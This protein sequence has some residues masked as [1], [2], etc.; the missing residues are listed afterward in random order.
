VTAAVPVRARGP[1][2]AIAGNPNCGKTTL[3]NR[4]TGLRQKVGN[5]AGVTV[6]RK[7]GDFFF[8]SGMVHLVD[9][10][11]VHSLSAQSEEQ[12]IACEVLLGTRPELD[13]LDGVVV[14][15][16]STTL[17]K[18]LYLVLQ[19][20]ST[21]LPSALVLNMA[22]ELELRRGKIDVPKLSE[23]L[24]VPVV[25]ISATRGTGLAG[26]RDLLIKWTKRAAAPA[27]GALAAATHTESAARWRRESKRIADTVLLRAPDEHPWTDR[28]DGVVMHKVFG[29]VLFALVVLGVFQAVF[30]WAQPLMNAVDGVFSRAADLAR[31]AAWLGPTSSFV[32]DGVIAGVGAVVI[33]LPQIL[34]IFFFLSLLENSGY[35]ARAALVM[36]KLMD[37]IGLQG[38]SFLPLISSYACAIPGI[39]ATRTIENKRDRLATMFVAPFM[40]CSA[41]LPVYSLFIAAFVPNRPVLGSF[42]G[43]RAFTLLALYAAGF[44]AALFTTRILKSTILSSDPVPFILDVPPYRWPQW[45]GVVLLLWDRSKAFLK[46]AGTVILF[47]NIVMWALASY[48][49]GPNGERNI[50]TSVAGRLGHIIE[51]VIRP[52]GFNWK[53]GIGLIS[54]Q[55]AREVMVSTLATIY[56]VDETKDASSLQKDLQQDM[57]PVKAVSLL[58]FF[59]FAMQC[60]STLAI[61]RRETGSWKIP[62]LMFVYMNSLAYA[63]SFLIYQGGRLL[64]LP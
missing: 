39:M 21:G 9:L 43:L 32:A 10:P 56:S 1:V 24:G 5:Y 44:A 38:K 45:K 11:G 3:F 53:I 2:V 54:A 52:L 37:K 20:L 14:V 19:I 51:P 23:M 12:R 62:A 33:F 50:E 8:P 18:S 30:S 34:I 28:I 60:T 16:D 41:R 25:L 35:L 27:P 17:E 22:D 13:A 46:R 15:A 6:E 40:T 63:A 29:P 59:A 55:A 26:L 61:V 7:E 4:L 58:I 42:L 31:G 64:G 48:P 49:K 57:T 47:V 36:D